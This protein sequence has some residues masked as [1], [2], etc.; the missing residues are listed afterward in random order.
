MLVG[1]LKIQIGRAFK[2]T[3]FL[4]DKGMGGAGIKPYIENVDDLL[5]ILGLV[6]GTEEPAC[7]GGKPAIGPL[8][9]HCRH[10]AI[11]HGLVT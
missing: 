11:D 8:F 3:P 7:I 1:S 2:V 4:K 6:V 10:D 5:V 9:P